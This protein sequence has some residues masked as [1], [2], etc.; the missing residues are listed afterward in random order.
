VSQ[1]ESTEASILIGQC[2]DCGTDIRPRL[3]LELAAAH[4]RTPQPITP[5][6]LILCPNCRKQFVI[7]LSPAVAS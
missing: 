3:R 5:E 4:R 2:P 1:N 7:S 6:L